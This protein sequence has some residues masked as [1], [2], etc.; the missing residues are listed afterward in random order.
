MKSGRCCPW[1]DSDG[2]KIRQ[3]RSSQGTRKKKL[4]KSLLLRWRLR[5]AGVLRCGAMSMRRVNPNLIKSL[6]KRV[7]FVKARGSFTHAPKRQRE[8]FFFSRKIERWK[9]VNEREEKAQR[10]DFHRH[11][12]QANCL[13]LRAHQRMKLHTLLRACCIPASREIF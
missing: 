13:S 2:G 6:Q 1:H 4:N 8:N 10:K 7:N 5:S 9:K 3:R 12:K 11:K